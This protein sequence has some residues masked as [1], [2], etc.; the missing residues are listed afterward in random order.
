MKSQGYHGDL[1]NETRKLMNKGEEKSE[2]FI[3]K[4]LEKNRD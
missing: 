3:Y 4:K 2:I 1:A